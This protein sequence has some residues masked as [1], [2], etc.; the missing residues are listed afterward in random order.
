MGCISRHPLPENRP[1]SSTPF[2]GLAA[3]VGALTVFRYI[4]LRTEMTGDVIW[5]AQTL[6]EGAPPAQSLLV[7]FSVTRALTT[8]R[9]SDAILA[10][11]LL[12]VVA[13]VQFNDG[14]LKLVAYLGAAALL[15]YV[16]TLQWTFTLMLQTLALVVAGLIFVGSFNL[17]KVSL[18]ASQIGLSITSKFIYRQS[19]TGYCLNNVILRS[20][21]LENQK[22]L[23]S[24]FAGLIPRPLWPSKPNLS[25]GMS[26]AVQ[27]CDYD[28]GAIQERGHSASVTLLGD[29][30]ILDGWRGLAV[31]QGFLLLAL[32]GITVLAA[33]AGIAGITM[34]VALSPWLLDFDQHFPLYLA[35]LA[36]SAL[37]VISLY[38][39]FVPRR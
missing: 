22:G 26:H 38:F 24:L 29:P 35:T 7:A 17:F 19:D 21:G 23:H 31:A 13:L 27:F 34:L 12:V 6:A 25:V 8:R 33:S 2:L 3:A 4:H 18:P 30:L 5:L 10:F 39:V 20:A 14:N 36:K 32:G 9:G 1:V 28:P 15:L 37:I 16:A 11:G